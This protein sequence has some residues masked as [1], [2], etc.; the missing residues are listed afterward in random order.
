MDTII[1]KLKFR[2]MVINE[3][4]KLIDLWEKAELDYKPKGR[5]SKKNIA[6]QIGKDN[7]FFILVELNGQIIGSILA[8][9]DGRKGWINRIAVLPKFHRKGIASKLIEEAE[10]TLGNCGIEI[11]ACLIEGWNEKSMKLFEKKTYKNFEGIK[12][13]T[14]RKFK[15]I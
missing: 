11:F 1:D 15:E 13:F 10:K 8:S 5:D 9:H 12:Y 14:K 2:E 6:L 4:D 7:C 3:Y